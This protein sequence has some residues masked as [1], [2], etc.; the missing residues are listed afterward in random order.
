VFARLSPGATLERAQA[1]LDAIAERV[2]ADHA[3]SY[4]AAAGYSVSVKPLREAL[5]ADARQT[6]LLLMATAGMVLLIT[7][8]NVGNLVLGR[9]LELSPDTP[10][11]RV[12]TLGE[13]RAETVA[14]ERLNAYLVGTFGLLALVVAA[15]GI[16]GVL[17]F[18]VAQRT[19]EIGIRM[20]L[21]A[22][23]TK[24][25]AMVLQDGGRLL[26]W[27]IGL[28][29]LAS[30]LVARLLDGL[31]FGVTP[32]DPLTILLVSMVMVG[33]GLV[34]CAVPARRAAGVDP[35]VAMREE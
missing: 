15:V 2:H 9:F 12:A 29:L 17:A 30:L 16:A 21:G 18:F 24:V 13:I 22:G 31:L 1:E 3:E 4:D 32:T 23:K 33:A 6:L 20:S 5:T 27:G 26:G 7:C 19:T 11:E 10:V 14:S 25:L 35:L 28:G 8:A 34:A